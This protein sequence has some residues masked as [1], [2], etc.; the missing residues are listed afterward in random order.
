[1]A[2][3][4]GRYDVPVRASAVLVVLGTGLSACGPNDAARDGGRD[5]PAAPTDAAPLDGPSAADVGP[6]RDVGPEVDGGAGCTTTYVGDHLAHPPPTTGPFAY[7]P[8]GGSFGPDR[9]GFVGLGESFVDPVFGTD[10]RRLTADHPMPAGN[11]IYAKNGWW[12]ADGTLFLH[13]RPAGHDVLDAATGAIVRAGVPVGTNAAE[14]SFDPVDPDVYYIPDGTTIDAYSI[15]TGA[16]TLVHDFGASLDA[17]LGGSLDWI[18]ASGRTF[19]VNVGGELRVYDRTTETLYADAVP[20]TFGAGWAAISPD[21]AYLVTA[22]DD[23]MHRSYRID[24]AARALSTTGTMFWNLCGD[25]GDLVSAS[26][27]RTYFVTYECYDEAAVYAVDVSLAQDPTDPP[28]QRA[29]NRRLFDTDWPDSGHF[30]GVS[31]GPLRDWAFVSVESGDD[32]VTADPSGFRPFEQEIVMANVLTGEVRRL[33]HHRS[34]DLSSSYYLTPRL[35]ASWDGRH[36]AWSSN[37]GLTTIAGYSDVYV[38]DVCP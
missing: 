36:V 37:F 12:N 19:L 31:T 29:A 28:A 30:S 7:Y 1:M 5:A 15:S 14:V 27:G 10:V 24:H 3:R 8:S 35:S 32:V 34:R 25:H 11:D 38:V 23:S 17:G 20:A 13:R 6:S 4:R 26:D 9:P 18:D 2:A 16:R 22:S 21:G 33:A